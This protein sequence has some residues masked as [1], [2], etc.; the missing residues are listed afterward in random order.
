[1]MNP[2]PSDRGSGNVTPPAGGQPPS[3]SG[4]SRNAGQQQSQEDVPG[5]LISQSQA[6]LS[7]KK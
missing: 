2:G 4:L 1:M 7:G 5:S 6:L 3:A